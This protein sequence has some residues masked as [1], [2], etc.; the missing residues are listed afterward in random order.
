MW[1]A[2]QGELLEPTPLLWGAQLPNLAPLQLTCSRTRAL[3]R[4]ISHKNTSKAAQ[5]LP[6]TTTDVQCG[7]RCFHKNLEPFASFTQSDICWKE[8]NSTG[9][10]VQIPRWFL[11]IYFI[12]KKRK[13]KKQMPDLHLREHMAA[14][15]L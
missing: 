7:W 2:G 13:E 11:Y 14:S 15:A 5:G 10:R 1:A 12:K 4:A 8:G 6:R 9:L 3:P